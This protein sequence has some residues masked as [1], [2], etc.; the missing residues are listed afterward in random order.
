MRIVVDCRYIRVD[1][2]DGISRFTVGIVTALVKLHDLTV[3]VCDKR[4]LD[5]L[6]PVSHAFLSPPTSI[7]EPFVAFRLNRLK[8]DV[9]F[10]PMQTMGS[11]GRKYRLI[12]TLHDLIYYQHRTPPQA[13]PAL[14]RILWRLY[15][16]AWW[17]GRLVLNRADLVATVSE[18]TANLIK[19]HSLTRRP[20]VIV[21]NAVE[22]SRPGNARGEDREPP[23]VRENSLIYMGSFMPYKNVGALV[24]AAEL[25]PTFT[26][27]LLS[28][29]DDHERK[30]LTSLAPRARL[31]FHNGVTEDQYD[32]L[33]RNATAL[34]SASKD[35]GFG[36]P[37]I[38]AMRFGTPVAVSDIPI[39]H[40]IGELAAVYFDPDSPESIARAVQSIA[41]TPQTWSEWSKRAIARAAQFSWDNS[42]QVLFAAM[43]SLA[44]ATKYSRD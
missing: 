23:G 36:I 21:P 16:L 31:V 20:L 38:E 3:V 30:R 29:I 18:T 43:R 14:V 24:R 26:L 37:V 7:L 2:P 25:L 9:V 27:H 10:T 5:L 28:R 1:S 22:S 13:L 34:V 17:P 8:P 35:E 15:H 11:M 33:L 40:E 44:N 42:A 4:Q 41:A 12:L 32:D 39:F 19:K 6:P